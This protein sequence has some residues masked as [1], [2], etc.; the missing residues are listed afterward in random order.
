MWKIAENVIAKLDL[1]DCVIYLVDHKNKKLIQKAAYGPKNID[2]KRIY[3]PIEIPM[4]IGIVGNVAL[5]GK[6]ELI[7]N[8]DDDHSYIVGDVKRKSELAVPIFY[9]K[10]VIG[11]IDSEH[12]E[13][14]FFK[15]RHL[16]IFNM[17]SSLLE[18][19]FSRLKEQEIKEVLQRE[20]ITLNKNLEK[21]IDHKSKENTELNHKILIQEKKVIIGEI[22]AIIAH[23]MNT[24]LA[25]IK[26]GSEAILF[27]LNRIMEAQ[28]ERPISK[29][30]LVFILP[31]I[32][33][34]GNE[35]N[36]RRKNIRKRIQEIE[37]KLND[38]GK[39]FK[40]EVILLLTK[41]NITETED[42]SALSKIKNPLNT[43]NLLYDINSIYG[44]NQSLIEMSKKTSTSIANLKSFVLNDEKKVKKSTQLN[45]TFYGLEQHVQLHYPEVL[46][47]VDI[48]KEVSIM[49]FDFQTIQLWSNLTSLILDNA[50]FGTNPIISF[51]SFKKAKTFGIK[52]NCQTLKIKKAIFDND[53]LSKRFLDFEEH[54]T[55]LSLNIIK[56]ILDD[57]NAHFQCITEGECIN[58]TLSFNE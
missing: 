26:A 43:L 31:R 18:S 50:E 19:H 3:K 1:D 15:E 44:F 7:T 10:E 49:A 22:A 6:H 14:N 54:S 17:I 9:K 32:H 13:L 51:T 12:P 55:K 42:L 38:L 41:L 4:G 47:K 45:S 56:T 28:I 35:E 16:Y 23:E 48:D 53:L 36:N 21:E 8:A 27:L 2:Y 33:P 30:D 34:I 29:E 25:S 20:I 39:S 37:S 58:M 57:H 52:I 11:V 40:H 24:P 5:T 46:I